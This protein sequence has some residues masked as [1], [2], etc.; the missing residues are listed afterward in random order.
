[1]NLSAPCWT[2][3]LWLQVPVRTFSVQHPPLH[4][5]CNVFCRPHSCSMIQWSDC[6]RITMRSAYHD[7]LVKNT[8]L[9]FTMFNR[10][11]P[12]SVDALE[13]CDMRTYSD[14]NSCAD[15]QYEQAGNE[16]RRL[17]C[18]S[19]SAVIYS[20]E[21][22][23]ETQRRRKIGQANKG[24]VPWNK[25][26]K[27]SAETCARIKQRTIEALRDPKVRR[28]MSEALRAH[29]DI[30]KKKIGI[31]LRRLWGERLKWKQ[32]GEKFYLLWTESIAEAARKGGID[33]EELD[34]GSYEKKKI[35]IDVQQL[36]QA[37]EKAMKKKMKQI[38]AQERARKKAR[39]AKEKEHEDRDKIKRQKRKKTHKGKAIT[40]ESKLSAW[41]TQIHRE[42]S[43][44]RQH[45]IQS[46]VMVS[47]YPILEKVDLKLMEKEKIQNKVSFAD[48]IRAAKSK[49]SIST[50]I[51]ALTTS[52][53]PADK[54]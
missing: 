3:H 11:F 50:G 1:M 21:E 52:F 24:R 46:E 29:S 10:A 39:L 40:R 17:N 31:S 30:V 38:R 13:S 22:M 41:L 15:L 53:S 8:P 26:R 19:D 54:T 23:K 12:S 4:H 16:E 27:H 44:N 18:Q 35:E 45:V 2:Y 36:H 7:C 28:K 33:E 34:W 42:K 6:K 43:I 5:I 51:E 9:P 20:T 48:Q 49:R 37:A 47:N 14:P 25:G 32:L